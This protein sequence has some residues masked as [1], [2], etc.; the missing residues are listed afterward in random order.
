[1]RPVAKWKWITVLAASALAGSACAAIA[2][3]TLH[4]NATA[5]P[6]AQPVPVDPAEIEGLIFERQQIMLQLDKDSEM[7]GLIVAGLAPKEKLAEVARAVAQGAKDSKASFASPVPGGRTRP[8]MWSNRADFDA[9]MDAFVAKSAEM[10]R[11][12][13]TG[14]VALVTS[15]LGDALP[16][17][18]CH[19]LYRM[20][21]QPV[22]VSPA[23]GQPASR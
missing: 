18:A 8:E 3:E 16:C 9:R 22:R 21:K 23:A 1:M 10:A 17:K 12:A 15:S 20:P 4:A 13:E 2:P 11:I 14:N 19:D 5:V 6:G 7:L